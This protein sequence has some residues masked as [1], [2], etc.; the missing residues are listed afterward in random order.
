[1]QYKSEQKQIRRSAEQIYTLLGNFN[2]FTP[3]LSGKVEH[4]DAQEESCS[5]T[6][7]G[8]SLSLKYAEKEPHNTLKLTPGEQGAPMDFTMWIQ[9]KEAAPYD[10]RLRLVLDVDLPPM[11]KIVVGSKLQDAVDAVANHIATGFNQ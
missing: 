8:M 11:M 9:L 2:N 3:I 4:W 1:M 5:F 7:R 6:V 10:T